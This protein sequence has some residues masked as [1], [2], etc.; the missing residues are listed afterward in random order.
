MPDVPAPALP[1]RVTGRR[2]FASLRAIAALMLREMSTT[3]GRH[4]GGYLWAILEPVGGIL[5]LT[6]AFSF[7]LVNPPLGNSFALFYATGM[8]PFLIFITLTS[9]VS[10]A[11]NF[12]RPLLA[13]PAVTWVDALVA[14]AAVSGLT[15]IMAGTIVIAGILLVEDTRAIPDPTLI[16]G[17][18]GLAALLGMSVGTVNAYLLT[19]FPIWQPIWSV[20]TR[21]LFVI[22]GIF[23]TYDALPGALRDWIWYNPLVHVV[24]IMRA[25]FYPTY[26]WDYVSPLFVVVVSMVLLAIG[27]RLLSW[28]HRDLLHS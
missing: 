3:Y 15:E 19:R 27:V 25:G 22:S 16:A 21:P 11:I 5:V 10:Q 4:P 20:L 6:F 9:R 28:Y 12:S 2:R 23:F 14:R 24:G 8:L 18:C 7:L 17:A 1:P 26:R 13:Y